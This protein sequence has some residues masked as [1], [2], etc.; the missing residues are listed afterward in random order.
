MIQKRAF[1]A[2]ASWL[3]LSKPV[4]RFRFESTDDVLMLKNALVRTGDA[5]RP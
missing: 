4:D 3:R 5:A 2:G 1:G